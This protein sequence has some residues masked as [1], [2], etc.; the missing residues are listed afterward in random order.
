VS[1]Y[2]L[3]ET[4]CITDTNR[5]G[6]ALNAFLMF[7]QDTAGANVQYTAAAHTAM[8]ERGTATVNTTNNC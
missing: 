3:L 2:V 7:T 4:F 1:N 8:K 5:A 6:L